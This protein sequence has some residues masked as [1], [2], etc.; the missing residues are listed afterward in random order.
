MAEQSDVCV[1]R[2]KFSIADKF[3]D[4]NVY[5]RINEREHSCSS[6]HHAQ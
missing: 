2:Y 4:E 3:S 1:H 6:R 5:N